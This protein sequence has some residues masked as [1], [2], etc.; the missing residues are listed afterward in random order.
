MILEVIKNKARKNPGKIGIGV[1]SSKIEI[2]HKVKKIVE[3]KK[4][5]KVIFIEDE[6]TLIQGLK[7]DTFDGIV[8]GQLPSTKFLMCLKKEYNLTKFYRLALLETSNNHEFFFAPVGIDEA[9]NFEEKKQF[10]L[11]GI[12]LLIRIGVPPKVGILSGGR[13]DDLGRDPIVDNTIHDAKKLAQWIKDNSY[14]N[15]KNYNILI[16]DAIKND[17][18]LILAPTGMSG[19]LIYRTLIHLGSGK[20]HGAPYL[21]VPKPVIDTSRVAPENEYVSAIC[22]ASGLKKN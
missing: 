18:N 4:F 5:A 16:E 7:D 12:E 2:M 1:D 19:N 3:E 6:K 15:T 22:F 10:I 20:S 8:R 21:N 17:S 11:R 14:Q 13:E 9:I